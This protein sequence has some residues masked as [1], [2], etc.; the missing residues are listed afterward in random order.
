MGLGK[1]TGRAPRPGPQ[2]PGRFTAAGSLLGVQYQIRYALLRLLRAEPGDAVTIEKTDDIA[3]ERDGAAG[4]WVQTKHHTRPTALGDTSPDLW[5]TLRNWSS[6]TLDGSL[7]P[8]YQTLI[9]V[10]TGTIRDGTAAS[11]LRPDKPGKR[12]V[13]KALELLAE[14]ARKNRPASNS[15]YYAEFAKLGRDGQLKLLRSVNI[16]GSEPDVTKIRDAIKEKLRLASPPGRLD[17][18]IER[19]EGWW[20]DLAIDSMSSGTP[21]KYADLHAKMDDIRNQFGPRSLPADFANAPLPPSEKTA[22]RTFVRQ[23]EI[24][25]VLAERQEHARLDYYRAY[26][27]RSKWTADDLVMVDELPEYD[28]R[29]TGLWSDLF[30]RM[31]EDLAS[32]SSDEQTLR[33]RGRAH[34]NATIDK[35]I[36]IRPDV[37]DPYVMRGSLHML[38][39]KLEIGWHPNYV[40][41]MAPWPEE[42]SAQ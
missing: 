29:L 40:K 26:K 2:A 35:D 30:H 13:Q 4:E 38:A 33:A 37:S 7:D 9:L 23:L 3:L 6:H 24:I 14:A 28:K 5:K 25:D 19:V 10:T 27:Q 22:T 21:I 16:L 31:T 42:G 15:G 39:D 20:F 34:Y 36:R 12:D 18:F 1:R 11:M 32:S 41:I 8:R 17:E